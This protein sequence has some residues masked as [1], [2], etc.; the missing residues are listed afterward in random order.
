MAYIDLACRYIGEALK[1]ELMVFLA[2]LTYLL[3]SD[4]NIKLDL[5]V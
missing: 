5:G 3:V 4:T 1:G 2:V